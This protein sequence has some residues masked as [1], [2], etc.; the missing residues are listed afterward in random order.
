M[1]VLYIREQGA[2][3]IRKN[4]QIRVRLK[5]KVISQAPV[6]DL[7]QVVVYGNVQVTT[8]A[9]ALLARY[10]VDVIFYSTTGRFRYRLLKDGSKYAS[11]RR[12]QFRIVDNMRQS[13][14]IAKSV[15]AG[16]LENQKRLIDVWSHYDTS[17]HKH[18][19]RQ[20][21]RSIDLLLRQ[22]QRASSI[23]ILRG[24]EGKAATIYF[25]LMRQLI[26]ARWGFH[27]RAYHPPP[28]PW[29]ATLSFGYSLLLKDVLAAVEL[30]GLDAYVG[31][32]HALEANRPSLA[33]DLMEEF[34]PLVDDAMLRLLLSGRLPLARYRQRPGNSRPVEIGSDLLP[35]VIEGYETGLVMHLKPPRSGVSGGRTVIEMQVR[36]MAELFLARR[37]DYQPVAIQF[38]PIPI[39][40]VTIQ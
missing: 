10:A 34:R 3:V 24:F 21:I 9:A 29:N 11:L 13:L 2:Q 31:F 7:D 36:Q 32:F 16:K 35:V 27:Q 25:S 30:V 5:G 15:V 6:R 12:S 37:R 28:D 8:Q 1:T 23:D 18:A 38:R 14:A 20:G 19:Y 17:S 26:P 40:S 33:L 39:R 4:E 22:S